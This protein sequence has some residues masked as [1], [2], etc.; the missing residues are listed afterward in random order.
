MIFHNTLL[1]SKQRNIHF[2]NLTS[3]VFQFNTIHFYGRKYNVFQYIF[4]ID[5]C[6]IL[7]YYPYVDETTILSCLYYFSFLYLSF[8]YEQEAHH[9]VCLLCFFYFFVIANISCLSFTNINK[10]GYS[11]MFWNSKIVFNFG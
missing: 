9:L 7:C 8:L 11:L 2:L 10:H 5:K 6:Q 3:F 4:P 1:L